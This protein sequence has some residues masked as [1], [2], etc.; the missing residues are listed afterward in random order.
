MTQTSIDKTL[1]PDV[2]FYFSGTG[3]SF[4]IASAIA[5]GIGAQLKHIKALESSK[6]IEAD[7]LC[8]VFPSYDFKPPNVI[9]ETIKRAFVIRANHVVAVTTYGVALSK[10]LTHFKKT[11][12]H[13]GIRLDGG[14]GIKMPHNAVGSIGF[15]SAED[16]KRI[17]NANAKVAYIVEMIQTRTTGIIEKTT[18][19]ENMT[20]IRQMPHIM[21]LLGILIFKGTKALQLIVTDACI[22]CSLCERICPVDN[23]EMNGGKPAFKHDCISCFACLQW[24][25]KTAIQMGQYSFPD[26]GMKKYTHPR[27]TAEELVKY[28]HD[29]K[30]RRTREEIGARTTQ[31]G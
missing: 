16:A 18:I 25:P 21:K 4:Q 24:C 28:I 12:K 13:T 26:I 17:E 3:N 14:F 20:M 27:V 6:A 8:F 22:Q 5:K 1:K 29:H 15:S 7:V 9:S 10:A 31:G 23:I 2:V 11:L 19:L 30:H